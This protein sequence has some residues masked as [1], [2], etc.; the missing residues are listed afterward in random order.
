M[1]N[2]RIHTHVRAYIYIFN[3]TVDM[4]SSLRR[5]LAGFGGLALAVTVC[6]CTM[7]VSVNAFPILNLDVA[8]SAGLPTTAA[9]ATPEIRGRCLDECTE[10]YTTCMLRIAPHEMCHLVCD[11]ALSDCK[12]ACSSSLGEDDSNKAGNEKRTTAA[13]EMATAVPVAADPQRHCQCVYDCV[14]PFAECI[15]LNP[16]DQPGCIAPVTACM[17]ACPSG[18]RDSGNEPEQPSTVVPAPA[19]VVGFPV[20][21][22]KEYCIEILGECINPCVGNEHE[23]QECYQAC[24]AQEKECEAY[25]DGPASAVMD[26]DTA[27]DVAT[28]VVAEDS[29]GDDACV[30]GCSE[31]LAGCQGACLV[32]RTFG[33]RSGEAG[34]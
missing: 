24:E 30:T 1:T 20:M 16:Q 9:V 18:D 23:R 12:H 8:S 25:C 5:F 15:D 22:C 4:S 27:T 10:L 28:D 3:T 19:D 33:S 7:T 32:S 21:T 34:G 29:E 26:T 6:C 14:P 13:M 31:A 11:G 2:S 17:S